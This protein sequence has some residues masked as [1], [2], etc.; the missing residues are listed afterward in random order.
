MRFWI[1]MVVVIAVAVGFAL[2]PHLA[3]QRMTVELLGWHFSIKQGALVALL[4]LAYP[5]FR[6]LRW[7]IVTLL[8]APMHLFTAWRV[9]GRNRR[10][11]RLRT[12]LT[13]LI[14]GE[15]VSERPLTAVDDIVPAWLARLLVIVVR[16]ANHQQ[17]LDSQSE[18]ALAVA[19]SGRMATA[20]G[21]CGK[22]D[23]AT[24][25]GF[26]D[27]WLARFPDAPLARQRAVRLAEELEDWEEVVRLLKAR[28]GQQLPQRDARLADALLALAKQDPDA[29]F[30][31][32]RAAQQLQPKRVKILTALAAT[33][34][35][36][37]DLK[38]ARKLLLSGLDGEDALPLARAFA[39]MEA[40]HDNPLL[41]LH[42]LEKQCRK[43]ANLAQ[44]W[45]LLTLSE[46]AEDKVRAHQHLRLL[47]QMS[48][49]AALA[50]RYEAKQ[51][52]EQQQW[53]QAVLC[54][55]QA[56]R[57]A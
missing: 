53:E 11:Q 56:E 24:R 41:T 32:L 37:D 5:L 50:W 42:M 17:L 14:N 4:L 30:T 20:H 25:Q 9:G 15:S 1:F 34:E 16:P 31:H 38:T 35:A 26:V 40:R 49:G 52:V 51:L 2:F 27:A 18:D 48:G 13:A 10:E 28:S 39:A 23:A 6:S 43:Q 19:L 3:S 46:Q 47:K 22:L 44:R 45:L 36:A 55:Q 33:S 12:T 7:I 57:L 8:A 21:Q 29:A 54:Y